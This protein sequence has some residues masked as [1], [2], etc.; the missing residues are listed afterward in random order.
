MSSTTP[1]AEIISAYKADLVTNYSTFATLAVVLYE[2]VITVPHEYEIVWTRKWSGATWLC[3]NPSLEIFLNVL[4]DLPAFVVYA[5]SAMRVFALSGRSYLTAAVTFALGLASIALDFSLFN[6]LTYDYVCSISIAAVLCTIAADGIAIVTTWYKTYRRVREA[7]SLGV[8]IGFSATL[9]QY[10]T[11][12]FIVVLIVNLADG[13]FVLVPTLQSTNVFSAFVAVLPNIILSRFL[14]NLRQAD[15]PDAN[16]AAL[17]HFSAPNFRMPSIIGNLGETLSDGDE[18]LSDDE[19]TADETCEADPSSP[20]TPGVD[21]ETFSVADIDTSPVEEK[22]SAATSLFLINWYS[23]LAV[24]ITQISRFSP[25]AL[26]VPALRICTSWLCVFDNPPSRDPTFAVPQV[27]VLL[28]R[29]YIITTFTFVLGI[30]PAALALS[31]GIRS[32]YYHVGD[33]VLAAS[34]CRRLQLHSSESLLIEPRLP[35]FHLED[36]EV[37]DEMDDYLRICILDAQGSHGVCGVTGP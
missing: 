26:N 17:S 35:K 37:V 1:D 22:W 14:I 30:G 6:N 24:I 29:A 21:A 10:G 32:T 13:L 8:N 15:R 7:S 2:Y 31:Q 5:F 33:P 3:V 18:D 19:S 4:A 20:S 16:S 25:K 11:L 28:G 36:Q 27:F 9:L 23:M 34:T 12:Y